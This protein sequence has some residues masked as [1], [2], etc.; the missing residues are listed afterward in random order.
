MLHTKLYSCFSTEKRSGEL[1][2]S[3]ILAN[4]GLPLPWKNIINCLV[5]AELHDNG[6]HKTR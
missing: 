5:K 3:I 2:K 4:Y 6:H 1:L